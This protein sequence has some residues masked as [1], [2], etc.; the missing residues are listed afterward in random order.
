MS[1]RPFLLLLTVIVHK[2]VTD[3]LIQNIM[4]TEKKIEKLKA[5]GWNVVFNELRFKHEASRGCCKY[6]ASN[7][8]D[9]YKSIKN[10]F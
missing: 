7:I 3:K 1:K 10:D 6:E 9:L 5:N 4:T 2:I 8:T